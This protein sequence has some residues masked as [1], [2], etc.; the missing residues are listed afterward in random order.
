MESWVGYGIVGVSINSWVWVWSRGCG[1]G[2]M[3]VSINSWVW[4]WVWSRGCGYG[5]VGVVMESWVWL[6]SRGCG[7]EVVDVVMKSWVWVW[8]RGCGYGVV[9]VVIMGRWCGYGVVGVGMESWVWVWSRGCG[10]GVV[11]V[12]IHRARASSQSFDIR[13]KVKHHRRHNGSEW[14]QNIQPSEQEEEL[15]FILQS[16][17]YAYVIE[18]DIGTP[19]QKL[20]FLIDTGSSNMAIAGPKCQ[21]QWGSKC[22]IDNFY[23]PDKSTS[24]RDIKIPIETQYGKGAWSGD[25]YQDVVAF[26]EN[27]PNTLV[28]FAVIRNEKDFFLRNSINEGIL[29]LAYRSL[30]TD[31]VTPLYDQLVLDGKVPNVFTLGLCNG[32]GQIWLDHPEPGTYVGPIHYTEIEQE[33]WYTVSM[34]GI[35]VAGNSLDLSPQV[36]PTAIVD[37]GTTDILLRPEIYM[38]VITELKKHGPP[39]DERFWDNYCVDTDPYQWPYITIYLRDMR[40]LYYHMYET[41][42][43]YITIYLRDM[44][45]G[46]FGLTILGKHYVRKQDAFHCLSLGVK[47]SV[48]VLGEVVM[49]GNIVVFDRAR[50]RIGFA[51]SNL[52]H[53]EEGPCGVNTSFVLRPPAQV[54]PSSRDAPRDMSYDLQSLL[55]TKIGF[56]WQGGLFMLNDDKVETFLKG[57]G[58]AEFQAECDSTL[59]MYKQCQVAGIWLVV[60]SGA[61]LFIFLLAVLFF[62]CRR[63]MRSEYHLDNRLRARH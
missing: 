30:A 20:E 12:A 19:P 41:C 15:E 5:V 27:G 44:R 38:A 49:E 6:W 23:F 17:S 57:H 32:M 45:G 56:C 55:S 11:G 48:G 14:R 25:M 50:Q 54:L 42:V 4:V 26:P 36:F 53:P 35:D 9:G 58:S 63:S 24:A 13:K 22:K 60:A 43:S 8:S 3:G 52:T 7:Y 2:V 59:P 29:G 10:Y 34:T 40:K 46:S 47:Q 39:V 18:L 37:S 16:T 21:D 61:V 31:G 51:P 28:E 1:Y 33:T 62:C